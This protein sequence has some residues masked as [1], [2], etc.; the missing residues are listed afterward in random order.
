MNKKIMMCSFAA[1]FLMGCGSEIEPVEQTLIQPDFEDVSVHDPSV[2]YAEGSY[3][4]IGSH[5]G[6]AK[7]E[8]LMVWEIL[9]ENVPKNTLFE[10]VYSELEESFD[11]AQTSTLW[12]SSIIQLEDG[13]Y[14]LYYCACEGSS[15]LSTLGVAVADTIEGPYRDLGVFLTSG[16]VDTEGNTFD[17]TTEPNAID[18]HVFFDKNN[19]LW[20]VYGSYSGGIFILEM[21]NQSGL[22][23]K[24][25]GYGTK[26]LGGNHSR[27]E[28]PYMIYN[29]TTDYYYL[30]VTYG[31]LDASGGYNMRVARSRNPDG[32]FVD[33]ENQ[34][35][36]DA[37]GA[38][39]SFFDDLS[40][41]PYGAKLMGNFQFN[42][43][44]ALERDGYVS[45]GHNSAYYDEAEEKYF[46]LF[47]TRFP[48]YD[49]YHEV[50][51]HQLF[52][53]SEGW[54]IVAPL[55]YAG[56]T[57]AKYNENQII[58]NYKF[59]NHGKDITSEVKMAQSA[60]LD[61]GGNITGE[62]SGKW[63]M[64]GSAVT[65]TVDGIA[66]DGLFISQWD[67]F[68]EKQTMAFTG[69]SDEGVSLFGIKYDEQNE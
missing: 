31:G 2:I 65:V 38:E 49:E 54:P 13:K 52:F 66:Y 11:Y 39:G 45:A 20:M 6:F 53:N 21:D 68:Q 36:I 47:H 41:E 4:A 67:D 9:S 27:I 48:G 14:Y 3:Y 8:D 62:F 5:L 7:T 24:E 34:D 58:G 15:P 30:F 19:Q 16:T 37:K 59:V 51:V 22:P 23:K 57:I 44:G 60:Q 61:K 10:D 40:I 55:R 46:L 42:D 12:A 56:E 1:C 43:V 26:L 32:P 50:R 29:P 63:E 28:A 18:P 17:G 64:D 33:S 69:M 25:Q 35:M